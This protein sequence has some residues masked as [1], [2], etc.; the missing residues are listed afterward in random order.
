MA[1]FTVE[2]V[3]VERKLWSGKA[4]LVT[5]ETTEGEIGVLPGHEPLLGQLA[6]YGVVTVDPVDGEKLIAGVQGGFLSIAADKVTVLAD[7]AVWSHEVDRA[8]AESSLEAEDYPSRARARAGLKALRRA[9]Q[10]I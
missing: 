5:A 4:T 2:L 3:S 6:D 1:E 7:I 9:E 8:T 10:G